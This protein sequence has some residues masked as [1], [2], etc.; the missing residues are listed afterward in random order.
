MI[1]FGVPVV[2]ILLCVR[3]RRLLGALTVAVVVGCCG[4]L[5]WVLVDTLA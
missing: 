3:G 4:G 1:G 5:A 2:A